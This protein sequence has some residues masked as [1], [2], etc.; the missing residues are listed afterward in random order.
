MQS[1]IPRF[2][3]NWRE[4]RKKFYVQWREGS[5]LKR[6][7]TCTDDKEEAKRFL[8]DFIS[9]WLTPNEE[10]KDNITIREIIRIYTEFKKKQH[11]ERFSC[12]KTLDDVFIKKNIFNL[13]KSM[14][15]ALKP[16]EK[17]W[18]DWYPRQINRLQCRE[19][20]RIR[21]EEDGVSNTTAKRSFD[22]LVAAMNHARKEGLL[23]VVPF[24]EKPKENPPRD[25]WARPHEVKALLSKLEELPHLQ[26]FAMLAM[27]TLSRKR[28]LLELQWAQVDLESRRIDFNPPDRQ[29]TKKRRVPVPI[30][31]SLLKALT[32]AKEVATTK[33]VIEWRGKPCYE[34]GRA[35][36]N[37]A[38]E[39]N[40]GWIT[41]HVLRHT[42]ATL[43]V[44]NGVSMWEIA[45]IMGDKLETVEKHYLK[46]HPDYLK[47]ATSAL[48]RIYA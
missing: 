10:Q 38:R 44:Q 36:R 19:F 32:L 11:R 33:H 24:V 42:G 25:K 46:H 16:I 6:V 48:D 13:D 41:P 1:G 14:T 5:Q 30:N 15:C 9:G 23:T 22:I 3:L 37:H 12:N 20:V 4:E 21:T 40:L 35:F 7:S 8:A 26:L 28:A 27:H 45:G 29:H 31:N 34:I 43:M 47:D 2:E 18:G 39:V 17:L